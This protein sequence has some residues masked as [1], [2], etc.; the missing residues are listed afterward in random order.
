MTTV[1]IDHEV[2]LAGLSPDTKYYYS[3][4]SSTE[5]HALGDDYFFVTSPPQPKPTRVWVIG[6]SGTGSAQARDVWLSYS[7]YTRGRYTDVWLMLGDNAYGGGSDRSINA[8]C[9]TCIRIFC[10]RRW[11][12]P[13]SGIM[14][15]PPDYFDIFT[16][17]QRGERCGFGR[18]KLLFHWSGDIHF[19]C[20]GGYYSGSRGNN[21]TMCTWLKADLG[22]HQQMADRVLASAARGPHN[23]DFEGDLIEMRENAVPILETYGVDLV[24]CGH[25]H[26]YEQLLSHARPLRGFVDVATIH[27]PG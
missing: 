27:A 9:S 7:N 6:D 4:G 25:S 12:G 15:R 23:S 19:I 24:L 13:L 8:V 17:E 11:C 3:I 1:N 10:G 2:P 16:L 21:G 5:P 26:N 18:R 14:M 20:L 22:E